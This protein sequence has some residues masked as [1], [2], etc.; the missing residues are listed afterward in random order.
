MLF[1]RWLLLVLMG[2]ASFLHAQTPKSTPHVIKDARVV[3]SSSKTLPKATVIVRD[4]FIADVVE[5][6]AKVPGDAIVIDGKGLTVYPGFIDAASPRGYDTAL[7]RSLGGPTAPED[8]ASDILAATKADNRRGLTPEFEVRSALKADEEAITPWRKLG[9]TVHLIAPDGGYFSGQSALVS[10]NGATPR[11]SVLRPLVAQHASLRN[12]PGPEYPRALMG[13]FAHARQTLLDTGWNAR[14][15]KAFE[16]GKLTGARPPFDPALESLEPC[17]EGKMPVVFEA[18]SFDDIHRALDFATEFKLKPIILGGR[19]AAKV[20]DRLAEMKVPVI[21]RLNFTEPSER[22]MPKRAKEDAERERKEEWT[23]AGELHKAGVKIAFATQGLGADR[24]TEKFIGNLR[25]SIENGLDPM[26]ALKA[27][28]ETPAELFK[29]T[30]QVGTVEKGKAAHLVVTDGDFQNAK[31]NVKYTFV[32]GVKFDPTIQAPRSEGPGGGGPGGPGGGGGRKGGFRKGG[33]GNDPKDPPAAK[34]EEAPTTPTAPKKEEPAPAPRE[35]ADPKTPLPEQETELEADRIPKLKTKGNVLFKNATILTAANPPKA[36]AS[37][38][39][40][41]AGKIKAIGKN[42][43]APAGAVVV[44]ATGMFIMPGII[45]SHA[46]FSISGGVNEFSLSVVP[47]VRV[48]DVVNS[49]DVQIYRS[50]AGG[51]TTARLL[52]GSANVIGGQDAVIKLKYGKP[53]RELVV[54]GPQG[55]KFALGENVKRTDG[56]FPNTRMGVEAVMVRA[57]SEA[58]AY[59][60]QWEEYEKAKDKL[61]EPRRDLRLE[62]LSD[63]LSGK[64]RVHCHCYRSDE[65][66]MLLRVADRFN[67]KVRSLQ[68][69]LEGYKV[70][71]EIAAHGA[72]CSL[73]SDWWAYKIEAFDAIP[74]AAALVHEAGAMVCL[75]S[76]SNELVRHLYQEAAKLIK[77]GSMSEEEALKTICIN[78]AKQ[79]G[80][81]GR[82]GSIEVGKDADIAIFNGHPL[83]AFSRCEMTLVE[84]EVYF[85]RPGDKLVAYTPATAG[86]TKVSTATFP[87]ITGDAPILIRNVTVHNP[88]K[89][90]IVADVRIREGKI[91]EVGK[92]LP[93]NGNTVLNTK[94]LHVYPGM[95]DAGTILGLTE[96]GQSRE[97]QDYSD[98]GDFQPDLRAAVAINPESELIPVTRANGVL[99][100]VTRPSG[101]LIAG[102]AALI[103]LAG[104]VPAEMAVVEQLALHLEFPVEMSFNTGDP[105]MGSVGR[106]MAKRQREEKIRKLRELFDETKR[107]EAARKEN[108]SKPLV[109]RL[110]AMLPYVHGEKPVI[111]SAYRR[112]EILEALK[113]ADELKFKMILSGATES[114]KVAEEIKKRNVPVILGPIMTMPQEE[115]DPYDSPY[116]S[117]A[118]L[119]KAGVKFCIR[120]NGSSNTRNLPYEAAMAVSYGL[121][122][123]EALKAVTI[124]PAEIL[125]VAS[126]LGSIEYGKR[127]NLVLTNGDILQPSTQVIGLFIDGKALEPTSKHTRLYEKYRERLKEVKE[128][129]APLGTGK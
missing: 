8:L 101:P 66:L 106:A 16:E 46:H 22:P 80:I 17:L 91:L 96:L 29:S 26:A 103:D 104:W 113:L 71:P 70:A 6:D 100:V 32:D 39:L 108:P 5:G 4:G 124:Y 84:G 65:I 94:T 64:I 31:T 38:L 1:M 90:A 44:D 51:V 13:V 128:G 98:A 117:A 21:L 20:K 74:F 110:E 27:L 105:T 82:T 7:R 111:V 86:P 99:S 40:I 30:A 67:F 115:Y 120:S 41:E 116:A 102:Q 18:D 33:G 60:K 97:T 73:F 11:E 122:P 9:F 109:P 59:K 79:L 50:L 49:K 118:K 88:G 23:N 121:P 112:G 10:L 43:T 107:Y 68:H 75:K 81:D 3:V 119:H 92:D 47:E 85:Q 36:E 78:P 12:I 89:E 54:D 69:V 14:R 37:D 57:F 129:K 55:V 62:A 114:W 48:K 53:A 34:K 93:I 52:H 126:Q 76:D 72:S 28:T 63:I 42:L 95:I 15:R 61:P 19:E 56:R 125:G 127:A 77:Y 45:D 87:K 58:Q 83:N 24:A 35:V 123:E 25:K 2:T